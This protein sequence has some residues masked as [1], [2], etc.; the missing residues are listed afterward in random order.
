MGEL[1]ASGMG[2]LGA[3]GWVGGS[4]TKSNSENAGLPEG[5]F[6]MGVGSWVEKTETAADVLN[7]ISKSISKCL[8]P[9]L[10]LYLSPYLS[11][12]LSLYLSLDPSPY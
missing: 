1:Q 8:S 12:H 9:Y 10:S 4:E 3:G 2:G 6:L 11:P 5:N 7:A